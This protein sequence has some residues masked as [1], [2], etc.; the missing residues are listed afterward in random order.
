MASFSRSARQ[1]LD[2]DPPQRF[3]ELNLPDRGTVRPVAGSEGEHGSGFRCQHIEV[4]ECS[5]S[6]DHPAVC[7][8]AFCSNVFDF[9]G[10]VDAVVSVR[11]WGGVHFVDQS[12]YRGEVLIR[13]VGGADVEVNPRRG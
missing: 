7:Q 4:V 6:E 3:I 2:G 11:E 8:V 1:T 9:A 5:I 10:V 13:R 12:L